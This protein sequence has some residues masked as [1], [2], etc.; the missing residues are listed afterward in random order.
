[1][2]LPEYYRLYLVYEDEQAGRGT[3]VIIPPFAKMS[4]P[5]F[6]KNVFLQENYKDDTKNTDH[7]RPF[8]N[9][10]DWIAVFISIRRNRL[11]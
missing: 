6:F 2:R 10:S 7:L 5:F 11:S 8:V 9:Q 1:M 4:C 3:P